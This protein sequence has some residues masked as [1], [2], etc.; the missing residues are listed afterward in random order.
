[1]EGLRPSFGPGTPHGKP[2]QVGEGH[3]S[4]F[5]KGGLGGQVV[6]QAEGVFDIAA[7]KVRLIFDDYATVLY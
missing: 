1:M 3:P 7:G 4:P 5:N 6:D 2:G